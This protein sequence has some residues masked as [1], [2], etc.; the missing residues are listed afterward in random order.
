MT[1]FSYHGHYKPVVEKYTVFLADALYPDEEPDVRYYI[2]SHACLIELLLANE[3]ITSE[4][5]NVL[6]EEYTDW[7][8]DVFSD[9]WP[10]SRLKLLKEAHSESREKAHN[11]PCGP[12]QIMPHSPT[13]LY[14]MAYL[15]KHMCQVLPCRKDS[16]ENIISLFQHFQQ[17]I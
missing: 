11:A 10:E 7:L 3:R 15:A 2:L 8:E 6:S 5:A 14:G 4:Q 1:Y 12:L 13:V 17:E 9:S 16:Y